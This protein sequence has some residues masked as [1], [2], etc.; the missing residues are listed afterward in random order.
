[1][2]RR[3]L[4]GAAL[5]FSLI[6]VTLP[7]QAEEE[8]ARQIQ[9]VEISGNRAVN[10]TTVLSKIKTR[11]GTALSQRELDEDLKRLY[12]TGFFTDVQVDVEETLAG[13]RV[14]FRVT[15]KP[16]IEKI[17]FKDNKAIPEKKLLAVMK[18]KPKEFLDQSRLR[19]D[20]L[21]LKQEY[22]KKGYAKASFDLK[23]DVSADNQATVTIEVKEGPRVRIKKISMEGNRTFP[24][25]RLLKLLKTKKDTLLTSGFFK[26]EVIQE[27]AERL[28]AFYKSEGFL[29]ATVASRLDY[30]QSGK[31]AYL[32]FTIEEG[33]RYLTGT[34]TVSGTV[35]FP[36]GELRKILKM[37]EGEIFSRERLRQD[38][39]SLQGTYFERGYINAEIN[40]ETTLEE[41][42]GTIDISYEI[43]ENEL[44]YLRAV[45]IR[46]NQRTRDV[47][48]RREMRV[49]PG[50]PFDGSKLKRSRERLLNLGFF[51]EVSFDTEPT[52]KPNQ[53]DLVVDVKE[54]KTGEFSFGAGFSSLDRLVGFIEVAQKNFDWQNPPTFVGD[55]QDLRV[56]A[57]FGTTRQDYELSWTEPWIFDRPV[58]FGFDLFRR[59]RD[60]SGTS[61]F[62]Y[63]EER[64]GGDVRLGKA[65]GEYNRASLIYKLE[66][67]K[68]S[69]ISPTASAALL[70]EE[71]KNTVSSAGLTLSRDTRD[72][73]FSP[74]HGYVTSLT[75]VLAGGP[76]GFDR[77]FTKYFFRGDA[78]WTPFQPTQVLSIGGRAGM[79]FEFGNTADVPIFERF[80]AGG[81]STIRGYEERDVGPRDSVSGDPIGGGAVLVG[82]VEYTFP[83]IEI[84]RGALFFDAGGVWSEAT[85][86]GQGGY[87]YGT[88]V[89]VRVKTP[90]GPVSVDYG[91]PLNP[92]STQDNHGR[93]HFNISRSF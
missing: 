27:D 52:D 44:T 54:K 86:I 22:E 9:R 30:N 6:A 87:R 68:I 45:V 39:A 36:E 49:A 15:E 25:K 73:I 78:Y 57:Q 38:I 82:N 1:M 2:S 51:D 41:E 63:D 10:E 33:R 80:F 46:G 7:V 13:P 37:R 8:T 90:I 11:S 17:Q 12:A 64:T 18:V 79:A 55:G 48:V 59:E 47:V 35:V 75:S 69:D 42:S 29:D 70:A 76:L 74:A 28:G 81:S 67:V 16:A 72:S 23:T 77:D 26:E 56:R 4:Y 20:L 84:L 83:I 92:D 19:Q 14:L 40:A 93:F 53:S 21:L 89:G 66:E 34:T 60:R 91:Y 5:L 24:R 62:S 43:K 32:T 50:E 85:D 58:S 65:F 3:F 88:G 31:E 71:G 61:G